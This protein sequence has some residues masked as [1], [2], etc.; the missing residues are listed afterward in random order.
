MCKVFQSSE[1]EEFVKKIRKDFVF[2]KV[3]KPGSSKKR[4][5]EVYV[6]AKNFKL[7]I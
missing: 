5:Y 2:V 3:T 7:R 4:S 6:V 1:V